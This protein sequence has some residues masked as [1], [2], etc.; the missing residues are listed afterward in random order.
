MSYKYSNWSSSG[1]TVY[2]TYTCRKIIL[3]RMAFAICQHVIN[4]IFEHRIILGK[5]SDW[6]L[7]LPVLLDKPQSAVLN[8]YER[9][10]GTINVMD[11]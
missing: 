5:I 3:S 10:E 6:G 7:A 2:T 8:V 9:N 11:F 1:D 4:H